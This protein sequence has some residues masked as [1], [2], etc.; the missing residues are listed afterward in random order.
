MPDSVRWVVNVNDVWRDNFY[1]GIENRNE[2]NANVVNSFLNVEEIVCP[3]YF[4]LGGQFAPSCPKL[5]K[6]TLPVS[7][8]YE[9]GQEVVINTTYARKYIAGDNQSILEYIIP[10]PD[11][12]T[13]FFTYNGMIYQVDGSKIVLANVPYA[14]PTFDASM[15]YEGTTKL[16]AS[17]FNK[18][19]T[20]SVEIPDCITEVGD[21]VFEEC[22]LLLTVRMSKNVKEIRQRMFNNCSMLQSVVYPST[23]VTTI[24]YNAFANCPN[25]SS[26]TIASLSVPPID[27]TSISNFVR[28]GYHPF[29][30]YESH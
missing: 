2:G 22:R 28:N 3:K 4:K 24:G 16:G 18:N 19:L 6:V 12:G 8:Y 11:N 21:N 30:R 7:S 14:T 17:C 1:E 27:D 15:L 5:R 26:L 23:A 9:D 25:L 29:H 20:T 10:E 13:H